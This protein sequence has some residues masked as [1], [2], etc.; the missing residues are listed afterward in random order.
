M[1]RNAEL[2][3][4]WEVLR[5][6]DAAR[7]GISI[8]KLAATHGVHQRTIRRDLEALSQAG[9]PLSD[10]KVN[11]STLWRLRGN[12]LRGLQERGLSLTEMCA[13][14]FSRTLLGT[15]AGGP[16]QEDVERALASIERALPRSCRQFL[17][18]LPVLLKSKI[19]GRKVH[20][21]RKVR[22]FVNRAIEAS[23]KHRRVSA[24]YYSQSS[25]R[26]KQYVLEPLRISYADG[27]V[28]LT[29]FVPEYGELRT[30]AFERVQTMEVLDEGFT[31]RPLPVEPFANSLGV[32]TGTPERV[33]LELDA[34]IADYV[35]SR[36]WHPSQAFERRR[37]GSVLMR[38]D[39]C[40]DRPLRAWILGL[41]AAVRVV[42]PE[43]LVES[44]STE[45][46]QARL[47]YLRRA[48]MLRMSA[49]VSARVSRLGAGLRAS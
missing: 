10:D 48:E 38:L 37:D 45:L 33:E 41:G 15:L 35:M 5:D 18:S 46:E 26:A 6:I 32:H 42:R 9:F 11:G 39:V 7:T 36:D 24:R 20:D 47:G 16:F 30:F 1:S 25:R 12:P 34:S 23:L 19:A 13:L 40:I 4:Q 2:I 14:Y 29:A 22:T 43:S 28:Y 8:A 49:D 3:R 31:P 27:G 21:P 17:D 44:I